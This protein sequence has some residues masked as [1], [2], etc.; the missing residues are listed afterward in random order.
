MV[1]KVILVRVVL[2]NYLGFYL[3]NQGTAYRQ[4]AISWPIL[5]KFGN[6][7]IYTISMAISSLTFDLPMT[8]R[9]WQNRLAQCSKTSDGLLKVS[10]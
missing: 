6:T 8:W 9:Y 1:I 5:V 2:Q 3:L 7:Q 4:D 10:S